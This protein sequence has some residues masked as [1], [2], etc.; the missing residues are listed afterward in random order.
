MSTRLFSVSPN[1]GKGKTH[2]PVER[3]YDARDPHFCDSDITISLNYQK[4]FL[5]YFQLEHILKSL[6]CKLEI[7]TAQAQEHVH[8]ECVHVKN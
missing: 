5:K 6:R 1:I 8:L 7:L 3:S 4:A 2:V